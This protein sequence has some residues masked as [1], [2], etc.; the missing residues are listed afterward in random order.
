[1]LRKLLILLSIFFAGLIL[2]STSIYLYIKNNDVSQELKV[3]ILKQINQRLEGKLNLNDF[4]IDYLD[5]D[6]IFAAEDIQLTDKDNEAVCELAEVVIKFSPESLLKF[7]L[8]FDSIEANSFE[9]FLIKGVDVK[10]NFS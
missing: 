10:W 6:L 8:D 9:L 7:K 4:D 5:G 2:I 1:M 3:F